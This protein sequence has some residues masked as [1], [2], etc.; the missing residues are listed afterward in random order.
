MVREGI[1][2]RGM[3]RINVQNAPSY[4]EPIYRDFEMYEFIVEEPSMVEEG[5]STWRV[6][7]SNRLYLIFTKSPGR[8]KE[9]IRVYDGEVERILITIAARQSQRP[10]FRDMK[11]PKKPAEE[12]VQL[13][14][15]NQ[16]SKRME[17]TVRN[18]NITWAKPPSFF[19]CG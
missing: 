3:K 5:V 18:P 7:A 9:Y 16:P 6:Y 13:A 11:H 2:A 19:I 14:Q 4:G 12:N 8:L 17:M 1:I 10:L 15:E